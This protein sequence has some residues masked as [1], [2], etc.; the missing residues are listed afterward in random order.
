VR[1][2]ACV[3]CSNESNGLPT[4]GRKSMTTN[5]PYSWAL[6]AWAW[7]PAAGL[8]AAEP[9]LARYEFTQPHMGTRFQIIFYAP[10]G[11]LGRWAAAQWAAEAAFSRVAD[12]DGIMSDYRSTSELMRLCQKAGSGPVRVSPDLFFV[13]SKAQAVSRLSGGAFDV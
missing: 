7:V 12:L 2:L 6:L 10:D 5:R 11:A 8:P 3:V 9:V 4:R 13:L 1:S